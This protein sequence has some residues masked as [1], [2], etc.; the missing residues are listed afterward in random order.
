M[1]LFELDDS[2]SG[3]DK[4]TFEVDSENAYNHIMKRFGSVINWDGD[5]MVIPRKYWGDVQEIAYAA[6]GEALEYG[7]IGEAID[8]EFQNFKTHVRHQ[9]PDS[10]DENEAF[11][12]Y[13]YHELKHEG[14]VDSGQT[15]KINDLEARVSELLSAIKDTGSKRTVAP[16]AKE[17][18]D[19]K[20]AGRHTPQDFDS[21]V[22]RVGQRAKQGPLKTVWDPV[23]RVYKN[24]PRNDPK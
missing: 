17:A 19:N 23:K 16:V 7:T 14:Q 2:L 6:G 21:M 1:N 24:V 11:M 15:Q 4:V 22:R 8:Q 10:R 3:N 9:Y 18:Q 20:V 12:R 5:A 13:V